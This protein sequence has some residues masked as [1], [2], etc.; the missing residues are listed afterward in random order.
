MGG[1][2]II[3]SYLNKIQ[4]IVQQS[5]VRAGLHQVVHEERIS[6]ET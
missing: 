3:F 4:F 1:K 6:T 2:G 5:L